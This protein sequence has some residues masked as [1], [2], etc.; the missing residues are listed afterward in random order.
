MR[1]VILISGNGSNLQSLIDN[2]KKIDLEICSVIS[3]KEDAFGLKRA[4]RANIST[5]FVD[6]N[7]FESREDFDKQL[8]AIIDELDI[9]LIILAGYMRILSS[10]FIN[11]FAGK[12]LN[13][14]PSLLPK[15]PG[16]NTHR[17]AIDAK[18]KY[19]GA[20]VH[21]VTEELDGGPIIN[22][23]IVEIDPIDTEYSLAQKVLE[24]EHI[25]YPR[26]I[27]WYTQNRLKLINNNCVELD[28]KTL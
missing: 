6:P 28:G 13:I 27:H 11:H 3:N 12:I 16:L 2:A 21:F 25:L 4:E 10:D 1:A 8:I 26:V 22:Q 9:G 20:T 14:H 24:K 18:E 7:R 5:N 17:K 19:H 23:E 15:F